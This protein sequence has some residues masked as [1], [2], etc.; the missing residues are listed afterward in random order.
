M[1]FHAS[2]SSPAEKLYARHQEGPRNAVERVF[3][4]LFK[5]FNLLYRTSRLWLDQDMHVTMKAAR[6]LHNMCVDCYRPSYNDTRFLHC[7]ED[8]SLPSDINIITTPT[9]R[10]ASVAFLHEHLSGIEGKEQHVELKLALTKH[11]WNKQGFQFTTEERMFNI[12]SQ[13]S[14]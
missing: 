6:I 12:D 3:G 5:K 9:A 8:S 10:D 11:I 13:G 1:T 2:P 14:Y 7:T 4:V